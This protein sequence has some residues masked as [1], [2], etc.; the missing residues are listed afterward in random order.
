MLLQTSVLP[1]KELLLPGSTR[2]DTLFPP[3]ELSEVRTSGSR[4]LLHP[5][6]ITATSPRSPPQRSIDGL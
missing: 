4:I 5:M 6:L 2:Q 1:V 3:R